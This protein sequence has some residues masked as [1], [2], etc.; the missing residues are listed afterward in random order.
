MAPI[1]Y[2]TDMTTFMINGCKGRTARAFPRRCYFS[3]ARSDKDAA[4]YN[5]FPDRRHARCVAMR[6]DFARLTPR[7]VVQERLTLRG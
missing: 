5:L 1:C 6:A 4:G 7:E 2:F 3:R